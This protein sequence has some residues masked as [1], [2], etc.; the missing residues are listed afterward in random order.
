[1]NAS[2]FA[3]KNVL[4]HLLQT[5]MSYFEAYC[6]KR[7]QLT[8]HIRLVAFT[9]AEIRNDILALLNENLQ[10]FEFVNLLADGLGESDVNVR[11]VFYKLS[12][13]VGKLRILEW[14]SE[15]RHAILVEG[16]TKNTAGGLLLKLAKQRLSQRARARVFKRQRQHKATPASLAT[17]D[18]MRNG[19]D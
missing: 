14:T 1:M 5:V 4:K 3:S 15:V 17:F 6:K 11:F 13:E 10:L 19:E 2:I 18:A 9:M 8:H 7:K 12:V 16:W